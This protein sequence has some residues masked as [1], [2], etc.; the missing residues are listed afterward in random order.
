[1][2]SV[3][4][5]CCR[6][7]SHKRRDELISKDALKGA[8]EGDIE[9]IQSLVLSHD[10]E[11]L[12]EDHNSQGDDVTHIEN[13]DMLDPFTKSEKVFP[14][15]RMDVNGFCMY[16]REAVIMDLNA[17]GLEISQNHYCQSKVSLASI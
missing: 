7:H 15:Y 12:V 8:K 13:Y 5:I 16:I 3:S 17:Q 4:V 9:E 2:G 6:R 11:A 14:F 10:L 1:M